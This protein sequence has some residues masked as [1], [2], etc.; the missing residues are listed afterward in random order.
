[1]ETAAEKAQQRIIH[2]RGIIAYGKTQPKKFRPHFLQKWEDE[3]ASLLPIAN[4]LPA[5][6]NPETSAVPGK[7]EEKIAELSGSRWVP[8]SALMKKYFGN[9]LPLPSTRP[10]MSP[11]QQTLAPA[12]VATNER[13][14]TAGPING[15]SRADAHRAARNAWYK[16]HGL[17]PNDEISGWKYAE[18]RRRGGR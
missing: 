5:S 15:L 2:L 11:L 14:T 16:E 7:E 8:K 4:P 3:I 12:S 10:S 17:D 13:E 18:F 9:E 1:M 6:P